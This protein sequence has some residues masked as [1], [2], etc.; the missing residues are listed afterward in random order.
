MTSGGSSAERPGSS[1][2]SSRSSGEKAPQQW[3][4]LRSGDRCLV[5]TLY[6][7]S[8]GAT[9]SMAPNSTART[10]SSPGVPKC[11]RESE[12]ARH[13]CQSRP[14]SL[15]GFLLG[16]LHAVFGGIWRNASGSKCKYSRVRVPD[17]VVFRR[18]FGGKFQ[19]L[20]E[21]SRGHALVQR[22]WVLFLSVCVGPKVRFGWE[23]LARTL[24]DLLRWRQT[25]SWSRKDRT[26]QDRTTGCRWTRLYSAGWHLE[27]RV[28]NAS[29][30]NTLFFGLHTK[31]RTS[32]L[33]L[34]HR[35]HTHFILRSKCITKCKLYLSGQNQQGLI[36]Q[37][38]MLI[39]SWCHFWKAKLPI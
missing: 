22:R 19:R 15:P 39:S 17:R 4:L 1:W 27:G 5:Q 24:G 26:G 35:A 23:G 8:R 20:G 14:P 10:V 31:W 6:W 16:R 36:P 30:T 13:S 3:R 29:S 28:P 38:E 11:V 9:G 7:D 2:S 37:N 33:G 25:G 34:G 18:W 21:K 32:C 12:V